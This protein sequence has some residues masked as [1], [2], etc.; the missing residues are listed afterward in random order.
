[1]P[2]QHTPTGPAPHRA[3]SPHKPHEDGAMKVLCVPELCARS[4]HTRGTCH[5]WRA[6]HG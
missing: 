5:K 1:M 3:R 6:A 2:P 4:V